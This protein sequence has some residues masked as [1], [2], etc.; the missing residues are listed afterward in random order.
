[1]LASEGIWTLIFI[2]CLTFLLCFLFKLLFWKD[3]ML[4][5]KLLLFGISCIVF[6]IS[7]KGLIYGFDEVLS[8]I[9]F[10]ICCFGFIHKAF[11]IRKK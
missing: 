10:G 2:F 8:V 6:S 4:D 9:G 1:M 3:K 11:F 7:M 5:I